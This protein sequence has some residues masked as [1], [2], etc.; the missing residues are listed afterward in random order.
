VVRGGC[1]Y[2][3]ETATTRDHIPPVKLFPQ[4]RTSDLITVPCCDR[5]N[6]GASDD[7]EYFVWAVTMS[8]KCQGPQSQR[9]LN[10]RLTPPLSNRRRRAVDKLV[11]ASRPV[12]LVSSGGVFLGRAVAY[13]VNLDTL[14]RVVSRC[15]SGLYFRHFKARVPDDYLAQ[16][17]VEPPPASLRMPV[18]QA[19]MSRQPC[20]VGAGV[21][22]Y[23]IARADPP[24]PEGVALCMMRFFGSM[25][26]VGFVMPPLSDAVGEGAG[27]A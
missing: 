19:L 17:F 23:W 4:P 20:S 5:C 18:A 9:V 8:R 2:C 15:L 14:N 7:D 1:A 25:I 3:G 11:D 10:Q 12:D 26:A 21:F 16:G 22:D 24:A 13:D 6:N 27:N